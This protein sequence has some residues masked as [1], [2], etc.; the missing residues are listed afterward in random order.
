[1]TTELGHLAMPVLRVCSSCHS[2]CYTCCGSSLLDCT[3]CSLPYIL[4]KHWGSC[5]GPATPNDYPQ[6]SATA[7]PCRRH[8]GPAQAMMLALLAMAFGSPLLCSI[9]SLG[10]PPPCVG[11]A[12][13][14]SHPHQNPS[15]SC[16][17]EPEDIWLEELT[18]ASA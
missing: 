15:T 7:R 2:S 5:S 11:P 14:R 18:F 10:C 4:D 17:L 3:T 12:S 9:L 1:M 16:W 8:L 13:A 6:P